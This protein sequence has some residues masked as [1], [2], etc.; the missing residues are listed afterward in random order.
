VTIESFLVSKAFP[1][2]IILSLDKKE[3]EDGNERRTAFPGKL[4]ERY[5]LLNS[6]YRDR[7][8]GRPTHPMIQPR[9]CGPLSILLQRIL[10][11]LRK[12]R[13]FFY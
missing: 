7:R 1:A 6:L 10:P 4:P 5:V 13:D 9:L 8:F 11:F 2:G 12:P 3:A